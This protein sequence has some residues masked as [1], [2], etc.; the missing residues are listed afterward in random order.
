MFS[1]V[2]A[3]LSL[4]APDIDHDVP[5][6]PQEI[7][8][9]RALLLEIIRRA[10][11]DW[12]LYRASARLPL[13][14]LAEDAYTWLFDEK[15]G[16]PWWVT[17]ERSGCV[18]TSFLGICDQL[19]LEPEYVRRHL[20]KLTMQQIIMAGRPAERRNKTQEDSGYAEHAITGA[21]DVDSLDDHDAFENSYAEQFSVG[22]PGYL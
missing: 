3:R 21:V 18:L 2:A 5:Y 9:C 8:R 19:D 16:H 1:A 14:Q 15:P 12:I 6:D 11:H 20:R 13:K 4:A 22:T 7:G 17:R 10:A